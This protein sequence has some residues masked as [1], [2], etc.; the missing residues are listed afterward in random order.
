MALHED[1][2]S[3]LTSALKARDEVKLRT[4]R[5]ILTAFTNELVA[6]GKTPRDLLDD[7][8][9]QQV[10]KRLKKQREDSIEQ[11]ESAG[12]PELAEPEKE[13]IEVLATYLPEAMSRDEIKTIAKKKKDELGVTDKSK[14]GVL[15]G[16]V[17]AE[18]K[19]QAE[20]QDVK[21]VVEEILS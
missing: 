15:I 21:A 20:G 12:R 8:S 11:Y 5:S 18:T 1:I 6:Q 4:I 16:A 19:N 10:I 3:E 2:R 14:M 9:A 13:E 17:M 7:D